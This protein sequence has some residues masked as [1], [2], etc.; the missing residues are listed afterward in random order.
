MIRR[1]HQADTQNPRKTKRRQ[2]PPETRLPRRHSPGSLPRRP[3]S[4][5]LLRRIVAAP[6]KFLRN[7]LGAPWAVVARGDLHPTYGAPHYPVVFRFDLELSAGAPH[8]VFARG[9]FVWCA[10]N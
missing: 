4:R 6:Y 5:L 3:Q 2:A 9:E 8:A 7:V 1:R 10:T